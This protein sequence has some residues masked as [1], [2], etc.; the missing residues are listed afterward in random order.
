VARGAEGKAPK[1][2]TTAKRSMDL[3]ASRVGRKVGFHQVLFAMGKT[4]T[5]RSATNPTPKPGPLGQDGRE[6]TSQVL[7]SHLLHDRRG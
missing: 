6:K 5:G 1:R 2:D 3:R 7:N 4:G